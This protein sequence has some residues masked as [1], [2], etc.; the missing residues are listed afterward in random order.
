M[1]VDFETEN[2]DALAGSDYT[3]ASGTVTFPTGSET[4]T[5]SVQTLEDDGAEADERFTVRLSDPDGATLEDAAAQGTIRDDDGGGGHLP[6]LTIEDAAPVA[7]GG[8]A[9]FPVTLSSV[10]AEAVTVSYAT[11]DGT[12]KAGSDYTSTRGTLRFEPGDTTRT[13]RVPVLD[14]EIRENRSR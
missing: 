3:Q 9:R 5:I 7:E 11:A 6:V 12:A 8:T 14:D 1:T 2:G 13:I 10:S 4:Q